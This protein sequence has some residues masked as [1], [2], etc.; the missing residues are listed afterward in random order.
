MKITNLED[1]EDLAEAWAIS[2]TGVCPACASANVAIEFEI[3]YEYEVGAFCFC[4]EC[5]H[6]SDVA[7]VKNET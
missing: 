1:R 5:K 6:S 2:I 7:L 4:G 3:T